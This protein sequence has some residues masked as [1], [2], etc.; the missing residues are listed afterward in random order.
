MGTLCFVAFVFIIW[1]SDRE[2]RPDVG[3]L[4]WFGLTMDYNTLKACLNALAL[5]TILFSGEIFQIF[6]GMTKIAYSKVDFTTIKTILFA[7]LFEEFIYRS[8]LINIFIEAG[9][10]TETYCVLVLPCYFAISH[11]HQVFQQQRKQR[12]LKNWAIKENVTLPSDQWVSIRKSLLIALFKLTYT[13]IFG[14]YSGFVYI[15]TGSL[16]PAIV[17]HSHCN[18]FGFPSFGQLLNKE[19][20]CSDKIIALVLYIVGTI[21]LFATFDWWFQDCGKPWWA[22]SFGSVGEAV[23]SRNEEL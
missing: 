6:R 15:R 10:Y 22:S 19:N 20:R 21:V 16:W 4:Q 11:L 1:W 9:V 12:Q 3:V 8:C 13:N 7:P 17:L 23:T 5:N 14:I 2:Q 18:F